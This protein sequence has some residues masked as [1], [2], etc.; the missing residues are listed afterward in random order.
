[1]PGS[2]QPH[3]VLLVFHRR[4]FTIEQVAGDTQWL[5]GIDAPQARRLPL[6]ALLDE[7]AQVFIK[8]HLAAPEAFIA[9]VILLGAYSS[10]GPMPIDLTL[11]A[12]DDTAIVELEPARRSRAHGADPIAQLKTLLGALH[13]SRGVDACLA[14][15]AV[16]LKATTGFDRVMVYRFLADGSGVVVAEDAAPGLE[17]F[18]GLHYPASDIPQQARSMYMQNWLRVIPQIQYEP[19]LLEPPINPRTGRPVDMSHC[20]LRSVSPIHLEYLRNMGVTATLTLSVVCQNTLWGMLVMHHYSPRFVPADLRVACETFAQIFSLQVE[21]K[22]FA[23]RSVARIHVRQLREKL[24]SSLLDAPDVGAVLVVDT[25]LDQV[26][27]GG[28]AV[29]FDGRLRCIG[30]T[31]PAGKIME[32]I[33][34][35]NS[36]SRSFFCSNGLAA[37]FPG[38]A[39]YA[40]VASGVLAVSLSRIP[41]DYVLWFRPELVSL[42]RWAGNP[43]KPVTAGPLGERLTPRGSFAEWVIANRMQSEP[44]SEIDTESAEALRVGLLETVLKHVDLLRRERERTI[45]RQNLLLAELDQRVKNALTQIRA[46]IDSSKESATSIRAFAT[47]LEQ[48]I[49]AMLQKDSLL[50]AGRWVG[51]SLHNV[52]A[53]EIDPLNLGDRISRRGEQVLLTPLEALALTLVMQELATNALKAGALSTAD[54]R[55]S[56]EWDLAVPARALHIIWRESGGPAMAAAPKPGIGLNLVRK[57]IEDELQ[58]KVAFLVDSSGYRCEIWLPSGVDEKQAGSPMPGAA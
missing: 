52:I 15:A 53:D 29:F 30:A 3:G 9:P 55:I 50:A 16:T 49:D 31:P 45:R 26:R 51:T 36:L 21:T 5:L 43:S 20:G 18:L 48:R 11:T 56:V 58:G 4:E 57:T 12:S 17:R 24:I 25:L 54:G 37:E 13:Q 19:A 2:I 27:A 47:R 7:D 44:W 39:A 8:S 22:M 40:D 35:L 34:W 32:L 23:E 28:A 1:M 41:H 46:L 38:A 6:F 42:V 14:A 10:S 33:A